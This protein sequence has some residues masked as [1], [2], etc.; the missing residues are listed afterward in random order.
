MP[1]FKSRLLLLKSKIT[2]Y[3]VIVKLF[4]LYAC[5]A[6]ATTKSDKKVFG[7][8]ILRKIFGS[9]KNNIGECE[10]RNNE[11]LDNLC[12]EPTIIG[13]PKSTRISWR[14]KGRPRQRWVYRIQEDLKFLNL[15]DAEECVKD[16]EGWRHNVVFG[17]YRPLKP[18]RRRT[19]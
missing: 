1:L 15:R 4:A 13:T 3:K 8:K 10:M 16:R 2:L 6:W 9:K 19:C 7:R 11:E 18:R 5:S 12:K 14:P 17:F